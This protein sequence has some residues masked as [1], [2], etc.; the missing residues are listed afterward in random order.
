[1]QTWINCIS[2]SRAGK[3][4]SG[5]QNR[6]HFQRDYDRLI[7]SSAFRRLQNKT[8]VFPL[9]GNTFVHNRLTHSLE[10]ASIG[11]SIGAITGE[12]L[13]G[14]QEVKNTQAAD[15]YK[16]DLSSVIAAACL[17]HD[18]G[19]PPFGHSGEKAI[20]AFFIEQQDKSIGGKK[21]MDHFTEAE[22]HDLINFEGNAN[23]LHILT[24]PY[25]G[26][27][28]AGMQLTY[29]TLASILKYPCEAR[30]VNKSKKHTKKY[31]FFQV[32]KERFLDVANATHM[33]LDEGPYTCYKRHPFVYLVEAADDIS[34]RII[35][36]EDAHRIGL[37]STEIVSD[38]LI[39]T[40]KD[41]ADNK[42]KEIA[43]INE[44]LKNVTD[45]NEK[46][47][48][49]RAK[50]IS[51]LIHKAT[52]E[53]IKN[54]DAIL[55]GKWNYTLLD[56]IEKNSPGLKAINDLSIQKIY[57]HA[58]V[59][60]VEIAGYKVISF[61]LETFVTALLTDKKTPLHHKTLMLIPSQFKRNDQASAYEKVLNIL[62]FI[63]GMTD[64]YA[65]EMYRNFQG[66]EIARHR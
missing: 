20:S 25:S 50:C 54:K 47:G 65:T 56:E 38:V 49:F 1:M 33:H 64:G 43:K 3:H 14:L 10:V 2:E 59:I 7:F 60:E 36:L 53:F 46:I 45:D 52:Q 34:Y 44:S 51:S 16:Y 35:D 17:A 48:Y 8:Q 32:D 6:T 55:E 63:A 15:F 13:A 57:D 9:P 5:D 19:N 37:L 28:E 21:L 40:I 18:V 24:Y 11:R 41:L 61:L 42:D 29:T 31:G 22:W 39:E 62:D 23:A 66:I 30:A 27:L 58:S 4:K 12:T 26:K